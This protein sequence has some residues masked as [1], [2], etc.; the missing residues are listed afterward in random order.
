MT[1]EEI[2]AWKKSMFHDYVYKPFNRRRSYAIRFV[3]A[4][5]ALVTAL[6]V[7]DI[8]L[9]TFAATIAAAVAITSAVLWFREPRNFYLRMERSKRNAPEA[10]YVVEVGADAIRVR[11]PQGKQFELPWAQLQQV[12][13][14]TTSRGPY[15]SDFWYELL[16]VRDLC[17][18]PMGATNYAALADRLRRLPG[19]NA[20]QELAATSS[21]DDQRFLCWTR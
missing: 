7:G 21:V 12:T 16:T 13:I 1:E 19:W 2:Q 11:D 20:E 14:V 15:V 10:E 6:F 18:V 5:A 4:C 8:R 9:A 3:V 17:M